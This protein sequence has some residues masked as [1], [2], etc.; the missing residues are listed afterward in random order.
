M[1]LAVAG[2]VK[3]IVACVEAGRFDDGVYQDVFDRLERA[4]DHTFC[5]TLQ[6]LASRYV[7]SKG[8]FLGG[9][10]GAQRK[11]LSTNQGV[12]LMT[13]VYRFAEAAGAGR[14]T[15]S[16]GAA[17]ETVWLQLVP[18]ARWVFFVCLTWYWVCRYLIRLRR[19]AGRPWRPGKR[20]RGR[21]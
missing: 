13:F 8:G 17:S 21:A 10:G 4:G 19:S 5:T 16:S 18:Q 2:A 6:K 3:E 20:S 1:S 7:R 15:T 9:G 12:V 14:S 11:G